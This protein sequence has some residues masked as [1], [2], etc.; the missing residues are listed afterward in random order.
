MLWR[1]SGR[2]L[3]REQ[4][5]PPRQESEV[6]P[7]HIASLC[8]REFPLSPVQ[9]PAEQSDASDKLEREVP[10]DDGRRDGVSREGTAEANTDEGL[11]ML[12]SMRVPS[13]TWGDRR[14][15]ASITAVSSGNAAATPIVTIPTIDP[16]IASMSTTT[17]TTESMSEA[18][19]RT[20]TSRPV[21]TTVSRRGFL[22]G[23]SRSDWVRS[24]RVI[25][26]P[27]TPSRVPVARIR[28]AD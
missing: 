19:S 5:Q 22:L 21:A 7:Q 28:Q 20:R 11:T 13:A 24:R 12:L 2:L 25:I 18:E 8:P 3:P 17:S 4:Q 6:Q 23:A 16:P 26:T 10:N 15:V 27:S 9:H 1:P 14:R